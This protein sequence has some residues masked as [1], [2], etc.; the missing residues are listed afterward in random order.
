M[1][2][3]G[4]F[5][6]VAV[7]WQRYFS[8]GQRLQLGPAC[9]CKHTFLVCAAGCFSCCSSCCE[10]P[11]GAEEPLVSSCQMKCLRPEPWS[12][13]EVLSS[14]GK[15]GSASG[16]QPTGSAPRKPAPAATSPLPETSDACPQQ[17]SHGAGEGCLC[18]LGCRSW[19]CTT[20]GLAV[21]DSSR[22][23]SPLPPC[24]AERLLS[25]A[26]LRCLFTLC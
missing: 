5:A 26:D 6:F 23:E 13:A 24:V 3:W 14:L 4:V 7:M 18:P 11:C 12:L 21:G 15:V 22:V 8:L 16:G 20:K 17:A 9:T 19:Q 25:Q 2:L 10:C 1:W